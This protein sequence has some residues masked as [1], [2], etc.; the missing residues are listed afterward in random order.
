LDESNP[1]ELCLVVQFGKHNLDPKTWLLD[2]GAFCHVTNSNSYLTNQKATSQKIT[3]A[4]GVVLEAHITGSIHL[5]S[6]EG[7]SCRLDDL[8]YIP[9]FVKNILSVSTLLDK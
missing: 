2:S 9:K 6:K 5:T 1:Q 4:N 3:V 8:Y 7:K